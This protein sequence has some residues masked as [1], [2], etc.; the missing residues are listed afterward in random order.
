MRRLAWSPSSST[1]HRRQMG[2]PLT[3]STADL[4]FILVNAC[5]QPATRRLHLIS[6][7]Q[8]GSST[9]GIESC[10]LSPPGAAS[11]PGFEVTAMSP[12]ANAV[13]LPPDAEARLDARPPP[14]RMCCRRQAPPRR[15]IRCSLRLVCRPWRIYCIAAA[16]PEACCHACTAAGRGDFLRRS[17]SARAS[18]ARPA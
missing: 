3:G 13:P 4:Q 5:A 8:A 15:S 11:P 2:S 1:L 17:S 18:R 12:V 6:L 10:D 16:L 9:L 7:D 14:R